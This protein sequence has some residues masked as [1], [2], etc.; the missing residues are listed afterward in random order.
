M[1]QHEVEHH[2]REAV[3]RSIS[4]PPLLEASGVEDIKCDDPAT[5][6]E[7]HAHNNSSLCPYIL[8]PQYDGLDSV[9]RGGGVHRVQPPSWPMV[10]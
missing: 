3:V 7:R 9:K 2:G 5:S 8:P 1:V 4:T 10:S 6:L